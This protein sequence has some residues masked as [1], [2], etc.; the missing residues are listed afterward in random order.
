M[1]ECY[2]KET[3]CMTQ[4]MTEKV[5]KSELAALAVLLHG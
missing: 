5:K 3:R 1:T 2:E 4:L